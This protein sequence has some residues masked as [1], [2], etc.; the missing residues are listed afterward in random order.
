[1]NK[2]IDYVT[3]IGVNGANPNGD[4]NNGNMPRVIDENGIGYIT[5]G[6]IKRKLRMSIYETQEDKDN[7]DIFSIEGRSLSSKISDLAN[8]IDAIKKKYVDLRIFGGVLIDSKNSGNTE[9]VEKKGKTKKAVSNI[10]GAASVSNA[11]SLEPVE[12]IEIKISR[13]VDQTDDNKTTFGDQ[14]MIVNAFYKFTI[15]VNPRIAKKSGMTE[16]DLNV[17]EHA[18]KNM[19][20]VDASAARPAGSMWIHS[21]TK[22]EH[23]SIDGNTNIKWIAD[24]IDIDGNQKIVNDATLVTKLI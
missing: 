20:I 18:L 12:P 22:I 9:K 21:L 3:Y 23:G 10:T 5:N 11:F 8:D 2:R 16:E 14:T 24:N 15:S 7:Y 6:C 19:F 17:L 1:M 13:C 4:P